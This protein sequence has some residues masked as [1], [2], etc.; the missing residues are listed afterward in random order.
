[1][2]LYYCLVGSLKPLKYHP[3]LNPDH[4]FPF[5]NPAPSHA[6]SIGPTSIGPASSWRV[7]QDKESW[8]KVKSGPLLD[9]EANPCR[10]DSTTGGTS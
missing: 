8:L 7:G 2:I 6:S 4:P 5:G 3:H 10:M 9:N 1:M